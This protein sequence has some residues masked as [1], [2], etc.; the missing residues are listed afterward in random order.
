[1]TMPPGPVDR[2]RGDPGGLCPIYPA[3]RTRR[4]R[5]ARARLSAPGLVS[6]VWCRFGTLRRTR[7]PRS[8]K[9]GSSHT[10]PPDSGYAPALRELGADGKGHVLVAVLPDEP[11]AAD[12]VAEGGAGGPGSGR[13]GSDDPAGRGEPGGRVVGTIMLQTWPNAG[14]VVTGPQEAEIRALAVMPD[15][16]GRGVGA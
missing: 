5:R 10:R 12:G 7:W 6:M 3:R 16:Q 1:M 9:S 4:W 2:E 11:P 8:G 14:H 13:G 15:V